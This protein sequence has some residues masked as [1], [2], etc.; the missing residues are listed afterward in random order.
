MIGL[1]IRFF[2]YGGL[3]AALAYRVRQSE[4]SDIASIGAC[5]PG[6]GRVVLPI[7]DLNPWPPKESNPAAHDHRQHDFKGDYRRK[8][9]AAHYV[10]SKEEQRSVS[11]GYQRTCRQRNTDRRTALQQ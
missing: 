6:H 11:F 2:F 5:I 8:P 1:R 4:V 3:L 7:A 10:T 9:A